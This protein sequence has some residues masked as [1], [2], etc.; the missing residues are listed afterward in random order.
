M[1]RWTHSSDDDVASVACILHSPG[2]PPSG[3][4][5]RPDAMDSPSG[6]VSPAADRLP[7]P[8]VQPHSLLAGRA[9]QFVW[10]TLAVL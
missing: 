2:L 9:E 10:H 7:E 4:S 8:L 1:V 3:R 5:R 6:R